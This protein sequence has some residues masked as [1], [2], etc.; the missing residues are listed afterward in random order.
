MESPKLAHE[1]ALGQSQEPAWDYVAA[2]VCPKTHEH[3]N[4]REQL[5]K[6]VLECI[7]MSS[8]VNHQDRMSAT[9]MAAALMGTTWVSLYLSSMAP[10][11]Q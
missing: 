4:P 10:E 3:Q 2:W 8:A 7:T 6:L 5:A 1:D 9:R 11:G